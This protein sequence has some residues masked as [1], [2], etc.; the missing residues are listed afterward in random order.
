M[1]TFVLFRKEDVTGA[2]GTGFIAEGVQF[3]NGR[4]A[5]M[6]RTGRDSLVLWDSVQ[7][8]LAVNGHGGKTFLLWNDE[9]W[10]K[11]N[12]EPL[13]FY[14]EGLSNCATGGLE[15]HSSPDDHVKQGSMRPVDYVTKKLD[16][17]LQQQRLGARE[18]AALQLL[19]LRRVPR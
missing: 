3:F 1:R 16:P 5:V 10:V 8:L 15:G 14:C 7:D 17:G 19:G 11:S 18:A 13:Q 9:D 4:V 12:G 2:S 6:W